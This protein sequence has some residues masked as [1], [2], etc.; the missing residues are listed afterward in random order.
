MKDVDIIVQYTGIDRIG[1]VLSSPD[2]KGILVKNAITDK[3]ETVTV[4]GPVNVPVIGDVC[5]AQIMKEFSSDYQASDLTAILCML[6]NLG[7]NVY[8]F[9]G[10]EGAMKMPHWDRVKNILR[11]NGVI[12]TDIVYMTTA[13]KMSKSDDEWFDE[14][15]PGTDLAISAV[16]I[17][18]NDM[19]QQ[20]YFTEKH[21]EVSHNDRS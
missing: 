10:W 21:R 3:F 9:I 12:C 16:E 17:L 5:D 20:I 11:S 7:A 18:W 13:I 1:I 4:Q 19:Q 14:F 6:S 2:A 15:H 8:A